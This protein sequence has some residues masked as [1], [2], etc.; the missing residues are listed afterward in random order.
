[1]LYIVTLD[2]HGKNFN[3]LSFKELESYRDFF[4]RFLVYIRIHLVLFFKDLLNRKVLVL[5]RNIY[6][7]MFF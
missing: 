3:R 1:M 4:Y 6:F 2:A 5:Y 7:F